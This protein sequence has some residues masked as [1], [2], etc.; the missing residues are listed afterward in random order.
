MDSTLER[1]LRAGI[2]TLQGIKW[3]LLLIFMM[4]MISTCTFVVREGKAHETDKYK[5]QVGLFS[6]YGGAFMYAG[7]YRTFVNAEHTQCRDLIFNHDI[8]HITEPFACKLVDGGIK[9]MS[10]ED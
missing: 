2:H 4:A 10:Q 8:T 6:R 7:I 5:H 1:L 9:D 3:T